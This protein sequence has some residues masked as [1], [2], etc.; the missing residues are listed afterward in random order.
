MNINLLVINIGNSRLALGVFEQGELVHTQRVPLDTPSELEAALNECWAKLDDRKDADVCIASVN[1]KKEQAVA[2]AA[3]TATGKSPMWVGRDVLLPMKVRT[4]KPHETGVDRV[5]N[6]AAAYEQ[7]Q[8][9]CVVVDAGTALTIDVCNEVGEFLGGAIAPG[10]S[11]MLKSLHEHTS[12]L[13]EISLAKPEGAIGQNTGQAMLQG[14]FYGI[15]GMV[16]EIVEQYAMKLGNWPDII[17]TGGDA[18]LL[19]GDWELV[20]AVSPDLTLYGIALAYTEHHIEH[21]N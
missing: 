19:F 10:A 21:E 11:L 3:E 9:A 14:A 12:L 4:E 6:V 17:C 15:R 7:M 20:H 2:R 13:P 16:K 1:P 8:T 18:K 5:L